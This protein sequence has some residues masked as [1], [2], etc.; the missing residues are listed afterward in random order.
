PDAR[1]ADIAH[2]RHGL[3]PR[4]RFELAEPRAQL[5]RLDEPGLTRFAGRQVTTECGRAFVIELAIGERDEVLTGFGLATGGRDDD[6]ISGRA[7][8]AGDIATVIFYAARRA[9][10]RRPGPLHFHVPLPSR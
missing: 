6:S 3:G 9:R 10:L 8:L 2:R 5:H 7:R 1:G 4:A